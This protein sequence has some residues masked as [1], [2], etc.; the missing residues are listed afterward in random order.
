MNV[1]TTQKKNIR[2]KTHSTKREIIRISFYFTWSV[3]SPN[4]TS[5][6]KCPFCYQFIKKNPSSIDGRKKRA[7]NEEKKCI[8]GHTSCG[9]KDA[10]VNFVRGTLVQHLWYIC[11]IQGQHMC[12][13]CA[14]AMDTKCH[15][16]HLCAHEHRRARARQKTF[17]RYLKKMREYTTCNIEKKLPPDPRMGRL[18]LAFIYILA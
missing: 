5:Y 3:T 1:P 14:T 8:I 9:P 18:F 16:T 17:L 7:Q 4:I 6:S 10:Y 15:S 13:S 2:K 11:D 12:H